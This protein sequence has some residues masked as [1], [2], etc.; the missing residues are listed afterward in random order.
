MIGADDSDD[1]AIEIVQ[2]AAKEKGGIEKVTIEELAD[3][4][5]CSYCER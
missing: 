5:H 1:E 3:Y 2:D 4:L